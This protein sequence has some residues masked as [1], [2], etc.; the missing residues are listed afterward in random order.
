MPLLAGREA[1]HLATALLEFKRDQ[2]PWA[3]VMHQLAKGYSDDEIWRIARYFAT[4]ES[5]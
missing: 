5:R 3:T 4:L 2:R 1:E